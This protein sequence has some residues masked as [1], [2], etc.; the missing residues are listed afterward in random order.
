MNQDP[1]T[2]PDILNWLTEIVKM[3]QTIDA[4]EWVR[5][6]QRINILLGDERDKLLELQQKVNEE[7][8]TQIALGKNVATAK[9]IVE[10]GDNYKEY[11]R[12]KGLI[13]QCIELIRISKLQARLV[14]DEIKGYN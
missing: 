13:E 6:S 2:I 9:L 12:Q 3:R 10:S 14:N 4:H 8:V 7:K 1:T 5:M 11:C